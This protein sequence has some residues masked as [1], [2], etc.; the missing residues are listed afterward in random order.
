[1]DPGKQTHQRTLDNGSHWNTDIVAATAAAA[2][3]AAAQYKVLR[4]YF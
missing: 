1:M 2:D 3:A 4:V